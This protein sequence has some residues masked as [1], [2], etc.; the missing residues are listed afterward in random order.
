MLR[1]T[2]QGHGQPGRA[3]K[4][5]HQDQQPAQRQPAGPQVGQGLPRRGEVRLDRFPVEGEETGE[6]TDSP[7][8]APSAVK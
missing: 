8:A 6:A 1:P 5:P 3:R 7:G 4:L 2:A